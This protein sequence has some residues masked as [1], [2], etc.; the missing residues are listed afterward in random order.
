ME[1]T[2]CFPGRVYAAIDMGAVRHNMDVMKALIG[3]DKHIIAVVKADA[4]GH[5]AVPIAKML[6]EDPDIWGFA[7]AAVPEA[8]ELREAGIVKPIMILGYVFPQD[9]EALIHFEIRPEVSTLQMAERLNKVAERRGKEIRIHIAVDTGM[10]RIG[11]FPDA[12]SVEAIRQIS[13]LP[14]VRI[15]GMFTHFARADEVDKVCVHTAFARFQNFSRAV[16]AAGVDIPLCHCANSA[17]ILEYP[18]AHLNLV[19]AGITMYGIYPSDEMI[20]DKDLQPV[21]QLK[22]RIAHLKWVAPGVP[23]SYGGTF[24]TERETQIATIPVGYAD[25]YPR[26]LSSKG[27]VLW[28]GRRAPILGR[29]CMDQFMVDVTGMEAQIGD[30]VTL[31]GED[32]GAFLGVDELGRLS[33]RFPYEFVCDISKRV[34]RVFINR[35]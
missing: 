6:E 31:M 23:V 14:H 25:G 2:V 11:F 16:R 30:E 35:A 26:S 4:Y 33:G 34:P 12:Q 1:G 32:H 9:D 27:C 3:P 13:R 24:V 22:S 10:S 17:T 19:R 7:V 8:V 29:V 28:K 21:M 15:E 20:R 18:D 5:G